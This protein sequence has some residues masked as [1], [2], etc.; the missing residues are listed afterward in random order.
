MRVSPSI[1]S[2]R[3]YDLQGEIRQCEEAGA[4]SFHL[5][6]MDGHFVPNLTIG[7][8]FVKAVKHCSHIPLETHLMIDRPDKYYMVFVDAGSDVIMVHYETPIDVVS[9]FRK[10]DHE[11]VK[12]SLVINPET[13]IREVEDLIPG[14]SS[15]LV[16]SVHPGFS[17][18]KFITDSVGK[19]KEARE[20]L[21]ENAPD[22]LLEI[23]G[24]INLETG[25]LCAEAGA[26]VLISA[27]YIFGNEIAKS[28][29]SLRNLQ[30]H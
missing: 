16:M 22:T 14:C 24:G 6:V 17:G 10:L 27:S 5:D 20:F 13:Q 1:I 30:K 29:T 2:A 12:R 28:I 18:Q 4:S 11:G 19:L 23:D 26:D 25:K 9:L 15:L 8:D 3:L 7:P 21:N